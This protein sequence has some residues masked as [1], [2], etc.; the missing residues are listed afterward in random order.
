MSRTRS[1]WFTGSGKDKLR[2]EKING[3][4]T[5]QTWRF[6][7]NPQLMVVQYLKGKKKPPREVE[8]EK[9]APC[10][11]RKQAPKKTRPALSQ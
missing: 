7:E 5:R 9:R 3:E 8:P 10:T 2:V 4:L 11:Q 6:A 1:L